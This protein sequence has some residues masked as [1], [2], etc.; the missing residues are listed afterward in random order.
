MRVI[1]SFVLVIVAIA[2]GGCRRE[3]I[4]V[5]TV[6]GPLRVEGDLLVGEHFVTKRGVIPLVG[7]VAD[8]P[9]DLL[10]ELAVDELWPSEIT[11][12]I[13]SPRN[14]LIVETH[15]IVGQ[16]DDDEVR[17]HDPSRALLLTWGFSAFGDNRE[18]ERGFR[19]VESGEEINI[20]DY[21]MKE[22]GEYSVEIRGRFN[23]QLPRNVRYSLYWYHRQERLV[24]IPWA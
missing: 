19:R 17:W 24:F 12:R 20:V 1:Q 10:D 6:L 18:F 5:P 9:S 23:K 2:C 22:G 11:M 7:I 15:M 4:T 13:C 21:L 3:V 8:G 14:G 16:A